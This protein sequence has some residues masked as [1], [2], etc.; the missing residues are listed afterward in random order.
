MANLTN[1]QRSRLKVTVIGSI[2]L[3][4]LTLFP[5]YIILTASFSGFFELAAAWTA[6]GI[7]VTSIATLIGYYVNKDTQRPSFINNTIVDIG[8][9]LSEDESDDEDIPL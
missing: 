8:D 9:A 2:A 1:V 6:W 4:L 7:C 3:Y 5:M